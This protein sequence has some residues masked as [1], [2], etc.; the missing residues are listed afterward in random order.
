MW[1]FYLLALTILIIIILV[2][3]RK[4][5]EYE[6]FKQDMFTFPIHF[7][8]QSIA[9]IS[10]RVVVSFST[11][12]SRLDLALMSVSREMRHQ[13]LQPDA[14]YACIPYFSK[15]EKTTYKIPTI[16][17]DNITISRCAEDYG[18][19]TKL[20]GC[21]ER[22]DD[23]DTII[24]TIDDDHVYSSDLIKTLAIWSTEFPNA[25]VGFRGHGVIV[26]DEVV[27]QRG[28]YLTSPYVYLL[29]GW[30]GIAYRRRFASISKTQDLMARGCFVSDDIVLSRAAVSLGATLVIMRGPEPKIKYDIHNLSA[31]SAGTGDEERQSTYITCQRN[32][33]KIEYETEFIWS[34]GFYLLADHFDVET[35]FFNKEPKRN[36]DPRAIRAGDIIAMR[37]EF[38]PR[39][40]KKTLPRITVPFKLITCNSTKQLSARDLRRLLSNDRLVAWFA[41]NEPIK[42]PKITYLPLGVDYHSYALH[43][44]P[45]IG[46]DEQDRKLQLTA[47]LAPLLSTRPPT[48]I[49]NGPSSYDTW[50]LIAQHAFMRAEDHH[51]VWECLILGTIPIIK[52]EFASVFDN[53]S[54]IFVNDWGEITEKNL[55]SWR[56]WV[57][58]SSFMREK[59]TMR[60][61]ATRLNMSS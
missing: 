61:W 24:I 44:I 52:Q 53:L 40:I 39:F 10:Q 36:F 1:Y 29:E 51:A 15:R 56:G 17:P 37:P 46:V 31:L 4:D 38:V 32:I 25:C 48:S 12:P 18:P 8:T 23:P 47:R 54:V 5:C 49:Y 35:F 3:Y 14:V 26:N 16:L 60:Y 42:H 20:L 21:L 34:K 7:D 45:I 27:P 2:L 28:T 33:L 13:T 58:S 11:I 55:F 6:P 50:D 41:Q 19:A 43:N 59:L 30:S 22:E 57:L 9:P